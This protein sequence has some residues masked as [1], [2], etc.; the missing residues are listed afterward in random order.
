MEP[1][2]DEHL[3]A[4]DIQALI[5]RGG[6]AGEPLPEDQEPRWRTH[7]EACSVCASALEN[8]MDA[9]RRLNEAIARLQRSF[10]RAR[11]ECPGE[12]IWARVSAGAE[13]D[14]VEQ[15]VDHA[16]TCGA[17]A[18]RLREALLPAED[19]VA[20]EAAGLRSASAAWQH[21]MAR[22]MCVSERRVAAWQRPAWY[23]W[24]TAAAMLL[25]LAAGIAVWLRGPSTDE[26]LA[27]A[28]QED[29]PFEFR[30]TDSGWGRVNMQRSANAASLRAPSLREAEARISKQA[31]AKIGDAQIARQDA[32]A[33]LLEAGPADVA[34]ALDVLSRWHQRAP[35]DI[36]LWLP[37]ACAYYRRGA[38][39]PE[40]HADYLRSLDLLAA[41]HAREP[42]NPVALFDL[43][44]VSELAGDKDR[45]ITAWEEFLKVDANSGYANEARNH[46]K[47]L[48]A[49]KASRLQILDA[50][51]ANPAAYLALRGGGASYTNELFLN[52]A[53][54]EW[55]P[56]SKMG[57]AERAAL[58]A[59]ASD[60]QRQS[61]DPFLRELEGLDSE[62]AE[63]L[64]RAALL[65]SKGRFEEAARVAEET[66][67]EFG[68]EGES[69]AA[70]LAA[71]ER[72][73]A[74]HRGGR[75][76]ECLAASIDL[77]EQLQGR[78]Y[79]WLEA[80]NQIQQ[81]ICLSHL[82]RLSEA[83]EFAVQAV[84]YASQM[85]LPA[86]ELRARGIVDDILLRIGNTQA[87]WRRSVEDLD[88]FWKGPLPPACGHQLLFLFRDAAQQ[89]DLPF[90]AHSFAHASTTVFASS[91]DPL[92]AALNWHDAAALAR[93]A[94][95]SEDAGRDEAI[96]NNLF[97]K[98]PASPA[99]RVYQTSAMLFAA[100][101]ALNPAHTPASLQL[102]HSL[103]SL[104]RG[105]ITDVER[106]ERDDLLVLAYW[107]TGNYTAAA[108]LAGD[109]L[110][111]EFGLVPQGPGYEARAVAHMRQT[112]ALKVLTEIRLSR[113]HDPVSAFSVWQSGLTQPSPAPVV[114]A[115]RE[116][117]LTWADL[118]E[119]PLL[120]VLDAR[121]I[122][123]FRLS[124]SAAN[125]RTQ[126]DQL[127]R[128][129]ANRE[130]SVIQIRREAEEIR[131]AL[132]GN[133]SVQLDENETLLLDGEEL[134]SNA[135]LSVLFPGRFGT[136][137][138]SICFSQYLR[139]R[140]AARVDASARVL[141]FSSPAVSRELRALYPPLPDAAR[142]ES[143]VARHFATVTLRSGV[144]ATP[145][146]LAANAANAQVFHFSGH[147]S[148]DSGSGALVL[149]PV[150]PERP[151]SGL[152]TPEL[153]GAQDWSRCRLA[154]LS[155][156]S[157]APAGYAR[158]PQPES[159]VRALLNAGAARVVASL[160]NVDSSATCTLMS[161]FYRFL[162]DRH[163]PAEA[164]SLAEGAVRADPLTSH[165]YYWAAFQI[166]GA[167]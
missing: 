9:D 102:V 43:A 100:R 77:Q 2:A 35:N 45:A 95:L 146:D 160:W 76:Q 17:C 65:T 79:W 62:R 10:Q 49:S 63:K 26:L 92:I 25:G 111:R 128:D 81:A 6:N 74:L 121:G 60:Y 91:S 162:C 61:R 105:L 57:S 4:S 3:S 115:R 20:S 21:A 131:R 103:E 44:L 156:C 53:I 75:P 23:A 56:R 78:S 135:P 122:S 37:L 12:E 107:K 22:R 137:V 130:S 84:R 27:R 54:S 166:Y 163:E 88:W 68:A 55:L 126:I 72:V 159:I 106:A 123:W 87:F 39:G 48:R 58:H 141:L 82:G 28:Y 5:E 11:A 52:V 86:A 133:A 34:S 113:E 109:L 69:A 67:I 125:L 152:V 90:A 97:A 151:Y 24:A 98:V 96:A 140:N 148:A 129:C 80:Q 154:V 153:I 31:R 134:L 46:L 112:A 119:G 117:Y 32:E 8:A 14:D 116:A 94:G 47:E 59:L 138:R 70:E 167:R 7:L 147:G 145:T 73:Y 36:S 164:L 13:G 139:D 108:K 150:S 161:H 136:P 18:H 149:A 30:L 93:A 142:E 51:Q 38:E 101:C 42:R 83:F 120:W 71:Y 66:A 89:L 40:N 114:A 132:L 85:R 127:A 15:L 165:P 29:R 143:Q 124:V 110:R 64:A 104:D 158:N 33:A 118:P 1:S 155:A 157:T 50:I 41:L 144:H 19:S 16:A 99:K